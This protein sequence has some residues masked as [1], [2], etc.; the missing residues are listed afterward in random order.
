MVGRVVVTVDNLLEINPEKR[1]LIDQILQSCTSDERQYWSLLN[2]G[3]QYSVA[4]MMWEYVQQG[5]S[6]LLS[7]IWQVDY[8][9]LPVPIETFLEEEYYVGSYLK[10]RLY[11]RWKQEIV[12]TVNQNIAELV[13][14]GARGVGKT[15]AGIAL[16]LYKLHCILC[17]RDPCSYYGSNGLVF[18]LFSVTEKLVKSVDYQMLTARL[19]ESEY[20]RSISG[21]R[22]RDDP[23]R[24]TTEV[25]NFP[26]RVKFAFGSRAVHALG[27]DVIAGLMDEVNFSTSV[28]NTQIVD[29]YNTVKQGIISRFLDKEGRSP[30]LLILISS[31]RH[32]GDFLD[33]HVKQ[34]EG[35]SYV[36]VVSL[37]QYD[38]K[39]FDGPRFRVQ[40][41][42]RL[43][44]SKILD[45]VS[46][47]EGRLVVT[48]SPEP[49]PEGAQV[50]DVPAVFY[51]S[52]VDDIEK[53]LKD[54]SGVALFATS[55]LI[56]QRDKIYGCIDK[57]RVHPFTVDVAILSTEDDFTLE[58]VF[59]KTALFTCL[60]R[61]R[62]VWRCTVNPS[63]PRYIHV[64]LGL[65][66]NPTGIACCHI[67]D[68]Q[69][70]IRQDMVGK[71]S[72]S[73]APVIQFDF[74]LRIWPPPGGE[75]DIG[76]IRSFIFY[77]LK[78][79]LPI[80]EVNFDRYAS[81]EAIQVFKKQNVSSREVSVMR[82]PDA[83]FAL[84]TAILEQRARYYQYKPFLDEISSVQFDRKKNQVNHPPSN[85]A[86][87]HGDVAD[88]AAG[89]LIACISSEYAQ[90]FLSDPGFIAGAKSI[91]TM[92]DISKKRAQKDM[93]VVSD[94]ED[95]DSI[96]KI[97]DDAYILG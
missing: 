7:K 33:S 45:T 14:G 31:A 94:Y 97:L 6:P 54:I 2:P 37:A 36:R 90:T 83:Y 87:T 44:S 62:D 40:V 12:T 38:V 84:K 27:Q 58:A 73:L 86:D 61:Y 80:E 96:T 34:K 50:I 67:A 88:A 21:A 10:E 46:K 70:T 89:A 77:L 32:E 53:S 74:F 56:P 1:A 91:T 57:T 19:T 4:E 78:L 69:E 23:K 59:D 5:T 41:G 42:D 48:T 26:K 43:H 28:E 65:R 30:G 68:I 66:R 24:P 15:T 85:E 49:V 92:K 72:R 63:T 18:G 79:G 71:D 55:L 76:K 75:V 39:A 82:K 3:E 16:L 25:L 22:E 35:R 13:L 11:D 93:W 29:L 47:E 17:L 9:S 20:F 8:D 95:F 60:D 52:Y 64:D 51:D 81:A